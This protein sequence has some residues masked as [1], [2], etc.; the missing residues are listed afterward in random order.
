MN[1]AH[2]DRRAARRLELGAA[3]QATL[4]PLDA[5]D[6]A[7]PVRVADLSTGGCR[8]L[9]DRPIRLPRPGSVLG[10]LEFRFPASSHGE[11]YAVDIV[12]RHVSVRE[13]DWAMGCQCVFAEPS[14][15]ARFRDAIEHAL[16][17]AEPRSRRS[18]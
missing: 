13:K 9:V 3:L 5:S 2:D 8:L 18:D 17:T 7:M 11:S 12:V 10:T 4:R 14:V 1:P 15:A 6:A 16:E